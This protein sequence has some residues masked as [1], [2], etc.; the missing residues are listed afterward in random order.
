MDGTDFGDLADEGLWEDLYSAEA[1][2]LDGSM[3]L[4][5]AAGLFAELRH[6]LVRL[7]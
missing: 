6:W 7:N 4:S 5:P 1:Q 3:I 2:P